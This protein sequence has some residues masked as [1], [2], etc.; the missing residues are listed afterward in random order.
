MELTQKA[1]WFS[2]AG[3]SSASLQLDL[4]IKAAPSYAPARLVSAC[5]FMQEGRWDLVREDLSV[6]T[7]KDTPEGRLLRELAERQPRAPDWRHAFFDAWTALG[8]PDFRKSTLLPVPLEWNHLISTGFTRSPKDESWRFP[9]AV[10]HPGS[11]EQDQQWAL[12]QVRVSPSVPLLMALREQLYSFEEQ[13]PLRRFL[14]SAVEERLGQLAGS[15]PRTLQLALASFLAGGS[16]SAPFTR[17][18]LET[19]E[20]IVSVREWKQP[21]SE[22]FFLEMRGLVGMMFAPGHHALAMATLAQGASL[23]LSLLGKARASKAHL[24]EDEQRWMGRLLWD[25]GARLLEQRSRLEW[26]TGLRLQMFGSELTQHVPSREQCIALWVELGKWE[27]AVKQAAYYRWP[28]APLVEES[29]APRARD[30]LVWMQAFAGK[31][32][33]P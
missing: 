31:G 29:C 25:V 14:L 22:Q 3:D 26:E 13:A 17:Q 27:E 21:S 30:E 33:L 15:S 1:A 12:E 10:M 2:F 19:L 32:A 11:L 5:W 9:L 23:G 6:S 8:R 28:L 16:L 24:S 4:A 20:K 18:E 7:I